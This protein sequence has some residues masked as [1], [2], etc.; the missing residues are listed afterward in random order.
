MDRNGLGSRIKR[1]ASVSTTLTQFA[2]KLAKFHYTE[3][4]SQAAFRAKELKD[5]LGSLKGPFMKIAQLLA[6]IPDF[7]PPEFQKS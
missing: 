7:L 1:Y 5:A 4:S 6:T 2:I 3:D